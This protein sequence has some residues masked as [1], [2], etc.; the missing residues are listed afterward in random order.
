MAPTDDQRRIAGGVLASAP[1][2][3]VLPAGCGK[4]ELVAVLASVAAQHS[5]R[6]LLLT[7]THAGVDAL[8]RRLKAFGVPPRAVSLG[9]IASWT[10][11][12]VGAYPRS[13]GVDTLDEPVW[14]ALCEG[15]V[16]ALS[17]P[18]VAATIT[19]SYD[20]IVVDEYQDC[21]LTQHEVIMAL[22]SLR[23]VIA[24]GD[25]L[26]AIY[27]FGEEELV[28]MTQDLSALQAVELPCRPW[29]WHATPRLGAYVLEL[30]AALLDGR[31]VDLDNAP[32]SWVPDEADAAR[33]AM[34][35]H[36]GASGS[37]VIL[38]RFDAQCEKIS[39]SL[40]G[41]F[42]VMEDVQGQRLLDVATVVES[43]GGVRAAGEVL[44][45]ARASIARLPATLTGKIKP[46]K[47]GTFPRF[48]RSSAAASALITLGEFAENAD[49]ASLLRVID[50]IDALDDIAVCRHEAWRDFRR[51]ALAWEQGAES[52][53]AA[54][55]S[56]RD[57]ARRSGRRR[58]ARSVSRPVLVKGQEF[59]H[60]VVSDAQAMNA[61]EL[62]VAMTRARSSLTVIAPHPVLHPAP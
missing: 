31:R 44:V 20:V 18:H 3:A 39:K 51:A 33:K 24:L 38:A 53:S 21:T 32:L 42:G 49:G 41:R 26:Q 60:C 37:A 59:D 40:S 6:V 50:A 62:Y 58:P 15:A 45:L 57:G 30:R 29:R 16:L 2:H 36:V 61:R 12:L 43:E 7:H 4:T 48:Q 47:A 25:P 19:A 5:Q 22:N 23:P 35:R 14:S 8:R 17:N 11:R 34:W 9:T 1:C 54:I 56:V 10:R 13:A 27:D 46:L 52:L 55:R 28:D